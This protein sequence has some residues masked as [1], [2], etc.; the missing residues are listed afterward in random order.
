MREVI[1][2]KQVVYFYLEGAVDAAS[3]AELARLALYSLLIAA[4]AYRDEFG[5]TP[6]VYMICDEAQ[7]MMAKN[8]ENVL[9]QARSHGLAC[10]LAH[11]TVSQLNPPGG[12]DLRELV[13]NSTATKLA[14]AVRDPWTQRYIAETSGTTCYYRPSYDISV[15][16]LMAGNTGPQFALRNRDGVRQIRIGQHTGPRLTVQDIL[17]ASHHPKQC[18]TWIARP[19]GLTQFQGWFPM[20]VSWPISRQEHQLRMQAE[21]PSTTDQ[22]LEIPR[23]W[24]GEID[25]C[26]PTVR[27][28]EAATVTKALDAIFRKIGME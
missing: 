24:P 3:V 23:D 15:A 21:W 28:G 19:S 13:M 11:Q 26:T 20:S 17:N 10:I 27:D 6:R 12:V 2:E 7:V 4:I 25:A 22:T 18:L 8:I 14:F 16:D 5:V 9:T 1:R